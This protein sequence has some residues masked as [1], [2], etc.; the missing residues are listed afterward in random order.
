MEHASPKKKCRKETALPRITGTT[1]DPIVLNSSSDEEDDMF[2][3][4]KMVVHYRDNK[5][6]PFLTNERL[7]PGDLIEYRD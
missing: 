5:G 3:Q 4:L 7:E 1:I 6:I 2:L